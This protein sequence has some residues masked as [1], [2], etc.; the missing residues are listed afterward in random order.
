MAEVSSHFQGSEIS[1]PS[2]KALQARLAQKSCLCEFGNC[3]QEA[4]GNAPGRTECTQ[5]GS[6]SQGQAGTFNVQC[7]N[8]PSERFQA[9]GT[10]VASYCILMLTYKEWQAVGQTRARHAPQPLRLEDW[11]LVVAS[12]SCKLVCTQDLRRRSGKAS[13]NPLLLTL[14]RPKK[15]RFAGDF[16]KPALLAQRVKRRF[17]RSAMRPRGRFLRGRGRISGKWWPRIRESPTAKMAGHAWKCL[18]RATQLAN[19]S[20]HIKSCD[21]YKSEATS[22]MPR[23]GGGVK[24][25]F[26][27]Q[28]ATVCDTSAFRRGKRRVRKSPRAVL[29]D[30][31]R[32]KGGKN[33][34]KSP[35][36]ADLSRS[37]SGRPV[38]QNQK[39]L[40][41]VEFCG[42]WVAAGGE[43][44]AGRVFTQRRKAR[45]DRN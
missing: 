34:G 36:T 45:K 21:N 38:R 31:T 15:S 19:M 11:Y 32:E 29:S 10:I 4:S 3:Y 25:L 44:P 26:R 22:A 12:L 30:H 24:M 9:I 6:H 13:S 33:A 43:W 20:I 5:P 7:H 37:L 42:V 18:I 40:K 16:E 39:V 23:P 8:R 28:I 1:V 17:T 2:S 35:K 41:S 14:I 27:G